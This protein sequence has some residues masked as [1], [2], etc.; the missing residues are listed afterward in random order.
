VGSVPVPIAIRLGA[1]FYARRSQVLSRD[2]QAW[3]PRLQIRRLRRV[4][5]TTPHERK[6]SFL[7]TQISTYTLR[8]FFNI[9]API[10]TARSL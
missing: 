4:I 8:N 2:V 5:G 1:Y 3:R 6:N 9:D 7:L 10:A